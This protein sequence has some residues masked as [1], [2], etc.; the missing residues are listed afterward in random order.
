MGGDGE[1]EETQGPGMSDCVNDRGVRGSEKE[2]KKEGLYKI[3]T[4]VTYHREL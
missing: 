2:R 4:R 3:M 1:E